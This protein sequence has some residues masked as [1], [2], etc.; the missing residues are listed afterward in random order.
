MPRNV[1]TVA[2]EGP[3]YHIYNFNDENIR[4][5]GLRCEEIFTKEQIPTVLKHLAKDAIGYEGERGFRMM[6]LSAEEVMEDSRIK[7]GTYALYLPVRGITAQRSPK[8]TTED[9]GPNGQHPFKK[10][11]DPLHTNKKY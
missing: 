10:G 4:S 3:L 11:G 6:I 7:P 9:Y 5:L 1:E 2:A 8:C